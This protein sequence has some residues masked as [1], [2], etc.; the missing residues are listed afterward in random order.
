M[1]LFQ[2]LNEEYDQHSGILPSSNSSTNLTHYDLRAFNGTDLT[3]PRTMPDF[4]YWNVP[5]F[6]G[7]TMLTLSSPRS[8]EGFSIAARTMAELDAEYTAGELSEDTLREIE[9]YSLVTG[10]EGWP[11]DDAAVTF[12]KDATL[13]Y[14]TSIRIALISTVDKTV[15]STYRDNILLDFPN[16][17]STYYIELA[18]PD[19]PAQAASPHLDLANSYIE[20]TSSPTYAA[21]LTDSFRFDQSL[22]SLTA[23]GDTYWRINRNSLVNVDLAAITGIRFRLRS[24]AGNMT[25][26]AQAMRVYKSGVYT[27]PTVSI[28]TK[29]NVLKRTVP[30]IGV[31]MAGLAL[32]TLPTQTFN[33]TRAKN[34]RQIARFNVGQLSATTQYLVMIGRYDT[35]N[36]DGVRGHIGFSTTATSINVDHQIDGAGTTWVNLGTVGSGA[37][38]NNTDYY[39]VFEADENQIRAQVYLAKGAFFGALVTDSL[40]RTTTRLGRGFSAYYTSNFN[41]DFTVDWVKNQHAEFAEWKSTAHASV[42]PYAGATLY[43][44]G[45]PPQDLSEDSFIPSGDAT[46]TVDGTKG[47]PAPSYKFVRT[48]LEWQGGFQTEDYLFIGDPDHLVARG[49]I[50]PTVLGNRIYRLLLIDKYDTVAW[51]SY[52]NDLQINQ[53]NEFEVPIHSNIAPANYRFAIQQVGL[54]NDT[55]WMQDVRLEHD[56]FAWSVS[57]DNGVT[58]YDLYNVL[59]ARYKSV[60]FKANPVAARTSLV[61]RARALT[62]NARLDG[63]EI[64]PAYEYPGHT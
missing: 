54:Y 41:Y 42:T 15:T 32:V 39:M 10:G 20:F 46:V 53:W 35:T 34:F 7:E 13:G 1:A 38:T 60:S 22:N 52:L 26:V 62:D 43:P 37:L 57:P 24:V 58:W 44:K 27:F 14:S 6:D 49:K 55:F 9:L 47:D 31:D 61:V 48:G 11:V 16:D 56:S 45:T 29:R 25:F 3:V 21:G 50:F 63:Y 8:V 17:G 5:Y 40:W 36:F 64:H 19:F 12:G 51:I 30:Q 23:G 4:K 33:G 59:N 28:D 18:L 2:S